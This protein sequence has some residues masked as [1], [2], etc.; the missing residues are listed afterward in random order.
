[1][2]R[3]T[4]SAPA[5]LV[6]GDLMKDVYLWGKTDRISP[7]AP[8]PVVDIDHIT[9]MLGG[10][11][12]VISNLLALRAK[13][14]VGGVIGSDDTGDQLRKMLENAGVNTDC[15]ITQEG[16]KTSKK[17]RI[18]AAHQ[19][20]VRFDHEST[21][22]IS[23]ATENAL[24]AK[25]TELLPK[26]DICLLSDYGKGV[27][28]DSLT[29]F[30]INRAKMLGKKV[31]IDPKGSDYSKYKG[32]YLI[33]PNRKEAGEAV[34]R[35]LGTIEMVQNAG[36]ELYNS[37]DLTYCVITLSEAGMM[38]VDAKTKAHIPT[39]AREVFDVTGAGDTVLS[40][41]GVALAAGM[42]M[43]EAAHF[44]NTAAAVAVSK[45][46]SVSV[47][48]E[49]IIEYEN[50]LGLGENKLLSVA[51]AAK[52]AAALRESGVCV[53]F[54][55]GCFD[56]LHRG[57]IEYLKK[58]RAL[59]DAL[60]VGLNSD[61]SVRSLKGE[62]RPINTQDDRAAILCALSCVD[63]VVIFDDLTPIELIKAV[64]PD[65]LTK[66]ADYEGKEVIG[67]FHAGKVALIDLV[68]G[69]STTNIIHKIAGRKI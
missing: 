51:E 13:V 50:R 49:E 33:T 24:I 6:V 22:K 9:D 45:I 31:L 8:V 58:S 64:A 2:T 62:S 65:I 36:Q 7:E 11:G 52:K 57:H 66:G 19:Q 60:I 39:K 20:V 26:I 68:E 14:F 21:E 53:V 18:M 48:L 27:L 29:Q 55:N 43:L 12:N 63:F 10:A 56:I 25:I 37:L 4:N 61:A 32:A 67:S 40:S 1:M 17:T 5:I 35:K 41:L 54:T 69:R 46:G 30:I 34:G 59:G 42:D 38:I 3:I 23:S 28:T 44:A 15:L 16:R 47:S